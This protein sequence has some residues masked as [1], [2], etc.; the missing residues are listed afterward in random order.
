[1]KLVLIAAKS[2][3]LL[4]SDVK[5]INCMLL[6]F[7]RRNGGF[8]F[9]VSCCVSFCADRSVALSNRLMHI[10][11]LSNLIQSFMCGMW[12]LNC[13]VFVTEGR[14][15]F[16]AV[17]HS[18]FNFFTCSL[19]PAVSLSGI[20]FHQ[21][22]HKFVVCYLALSTRFVV[23]NRHRATGAIDSADREI[24]VGQCWWMA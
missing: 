3:M 13:W 23:F 12:R 22:L 4:M 11:C 14:T 6:T 24:K 19:S 2:A 16:A 9:F 1:M 17:L 5:T 20:F 15:L 10:I 8:K 18:Q 7:N 21:N